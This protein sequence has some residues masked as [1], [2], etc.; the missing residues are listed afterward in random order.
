MSAMRKP[1]R[2]GMSDEQGPEWAVYDE[3]RGPGLADAALHP[4]SALSP[5]PPLLFGAARARS[6]R[7]AVSARGLLPLRSENI[8]HLRRP[9]QH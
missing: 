7:N 3:G 8:G 9:Q 5:T 2:G 4:R 1:Q 6:I